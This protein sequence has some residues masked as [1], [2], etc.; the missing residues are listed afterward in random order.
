M[1]HSNTV[2]VNEVVPNLND[3]LSRNFLG[4]LPRIRQNLQMP[5][6]VQK[7]PIH[8]VKNFKALRTRNVKNGFDYIGNPAL[9][10]KSLDIFD[11]QTRSADRSRLIEYGS[12]YKQSKVFLNSMKILRA[13]GK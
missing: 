10:H 3:R 13:I 9:S 7:P 6:Q 5:R 11:R 4:D 1:E 2:S 12:T 8:P